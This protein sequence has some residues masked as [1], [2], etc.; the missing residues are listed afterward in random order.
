MKEKQISIIVPLLNE[1]YF[2]PR[3][4]KELEKLKGIAEPIFVDG[5]SQDKSVQLLKEAGYLVVNAEKGRS[6]QMNTGAEQ[7]S[8]AHYLFVHIDVQFP[9]NISTVLEQAIE[10]K[11]KLANFKLQ[12]DWKHWF[13]NFNAMFSRFTANPF[14]YGDQGLF[15]S[16][17]LFQKIGAYDTSLLLMEGNDLIK[18]AKKHTQLVKLP[19]YLNV[20]ARKYKEIGPYKLQFLYIWIYL[21]KQLGYSDMLLLEK[22]RNVLSTD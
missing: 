22:Y 21:L 20:S 15:I 4:L 8:T 1:E 6:I 10:K 7:A 13:L 2:V 17:S 12:F 5:G 16:Q 9:K 11:I 19:A 14:Q 3:F 18:R